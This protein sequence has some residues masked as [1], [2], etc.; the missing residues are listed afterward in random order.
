MIVEYIQVNISIPPL[1]YREIRHHCHAH[2]SHLAKIFLCLVSYFLFC[3][4]FQELGDDIIGPGVIQS[5]CQESPE[6]VTK[7]KIMRKLRLQVRIPLSV[8]Q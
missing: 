3:I 7:L 6:C 1:P 5:C 8:S 2:L 4:L